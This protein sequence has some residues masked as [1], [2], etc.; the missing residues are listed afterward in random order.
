MQFLEWC[1]ILGEGRGWG[2]VGGGGVQN[3][4]I[5][6]QTLISDKA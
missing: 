1:E 2:V 3:R 4:L 5:N 6:N